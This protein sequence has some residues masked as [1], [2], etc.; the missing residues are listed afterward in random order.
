MEDD[1]RAYKKKRG[2][3][4]DKQ[5][6]DESASEDGGDGGSDEESRPLKKAKQAKG[7]NSLARVG[8]CSC[9]PIQPHT[10][11][12]PPL[13]GLPRHSTPTSY[14]AI[15]SHCITFHLPGQ[16]ETKAPKTKKAPKEKKVILRD[17]P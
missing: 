15:A 10:A 14:P 11:P 6:G 8:L 12:V 2:G 1:E 3:D 4:E 17:S 9:H 16:E 7:V 5:S 13:S